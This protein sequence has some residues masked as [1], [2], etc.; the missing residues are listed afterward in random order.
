MTLAPKNVAAIQRAQQGAA[1]E[2]PNMTWAILSGADMEG[3]IL[4]GADLTDADLSG[5][6][7]VD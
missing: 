3:A 1:D 4:E 6:R 2:V 5:A 7:G